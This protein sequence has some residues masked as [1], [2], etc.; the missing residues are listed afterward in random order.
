MNTGTR[1]ANAAQSFVADAVELLFDGEGVKTFEGQTKKKTDSPI[2]HHKRVPEGLFDLVGRAFRR[3]RIRHSPVGGHR[4]TGPEWA[5]FLR[6]VVTDRKDK[7][8]LRCA[9]LGEF[10][11]ILAS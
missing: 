7:I 1:N 8:Q 4:L 2:Q 10:T 9:G 6:R 3:S 5:D 11:P